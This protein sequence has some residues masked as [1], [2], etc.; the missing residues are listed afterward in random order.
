MKRTVIGLNLGI[1]ALVFSLFFIGLVQKT[2]AAKPKHPLIGTWCMK[3]KDGNKTVVCYKLFEKNGVYVNLRSLSWDQK[4][5][6]VT[7][8]GKY[9]IGN[10]EYVEHLLEEGG[11]KCWPP[12]NVLLKY[13][14]LNRDTIRLDFKIGRQR[15]TE[16]WH[17]VKH[18]PKYDKR[19]YRSG[20]VAL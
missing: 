4:Q 9:T 6:V 7:H 19:R 3:Y 14:F 5:F 10:N 8:W 1:V 2:E 13:E 12:Q 11:N 20:M 18:A 16:T 15:Y 17:R